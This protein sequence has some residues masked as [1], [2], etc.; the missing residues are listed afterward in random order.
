[1]VKKDEVCLWF[2]NSEPHRRLELLCGLLNMCLPME[3]RF[4]S[5]CVEDL[6]KRDFHDLRDAEHKA[7]STQEI[8]RLSN[9]L[10]ERTRS[11]LIVFVALLSSRN[12]TCSTLLYQI[13]AQAHQDTQ[14]PQPSPTTTTIDA[15]Y[16][17]E[18]A[19]AP[20][21]NT[22]QPQ[23]TAIDANYVKEVAQA[24]HNSQPQ[25]SPATIDANYV[26]EMAQAHHHNSQPQPTA[27]DA[28]CVKEMAQAQPL[29]TQ[30]QPQA[31]PTTTTIDANYVKEMLLIYTMVLHHPAF[32]FEQKR[33]IADLHA[34]A[35]KLEATRLSP[36]HNTTT[37]ELLSPVSQSC[38]SLQEGCDSGLS[39][40][41]EPEGDGLMEGCGGLPAPPSHLHHYHHHAPG[42]GGLGAAQSPE[43]GG[44]Q[45]ACSSGSGESGD[46]YNEG[47]TVSTTYIYNSIYEQESLVALT[48]ASSY[49]CNHPNN[50]HYYNPYPPM[51]GT[52]SRCVP[53]GKGSHSDGSSSEE[54]SASLI[55]NKGPPVSNSPL[56]SPQ[57]S[58]YVSPLQ[59]LSP[60][61]A[62]SPLSHSATTT[63][64]TTTTTL[65]S[66]PSTVVAS[67]VCAA[68]G[69]CSH[70]GPVQ[71]Q[72]HNTAAV[73][74][75]VTQTGSHTV[76]CTSGQPH[77][78]P[79]SS[80]SRSQR[81]TDRSGS[82]TRL[83]TAAIENDLATG[84]QS[85]QNS[86]SSGRVMNQPSHSINNNSN[87]LKNRWAGNS[88]VV[89]T[90]STSL[91]NSTPP[92]AGI[93]SNTKQ[94]P[95]PTSGNT[96]TC[97]ILTTATVTASSPGCKTTSV[98]SHAASGRFSTSIS[99]SATNTTRNTSPPIVHTGNQ[100]KSTLNTSTNSGIRPPLST[101]NSCSILPSNM[102]K[103]ALNNNN[104]L[105]RELKVKL[106]KHYQQ[107]AQYSLDMLKKMSD[108]ELMEM[109]LNKDEVRLLWNLL[110]NLE[111]HTHHL[112]NGYT[113]SSITLHSRSLPHSQNTITVTTSHTP[114]T[115]HSRSSTHSP[116]TTT[117]TC[118]SPCHS[119]R[120][121]SR[122]SSQSPTTTTITTTTTT[123]SRTTS[124]PVSTSGHTSP[125]PHSATLT[126]NIQHTSNNSKSGSSDVNSG[127]QKTI[128]NTQSIHNNAPNTSSNS[129]NTPGN[130]NIQ[131][132]KSNMSISTGSS[133]S[134]QTT[135]STSVTTTAT[136]SNNICTSTTIVTNSTA[137]IVTTVGDTVITSPTSNSPITT[138]V[139]STHC[140]A[141]TSSS[142]PKNASVSMQQPKSVQCGNTTVQTA[143]STCTSSTTSFSSCSAPTPHVS[144]FSVPP[145]PIPN[146]LPPQSTATTSFSQHQL[147]T[148]P[149]PGQHR[150]PPPLCV[151]PRTPSQE[152]CTHSTTASM[153]GYYTN[154]GGVG[155]KNNP[156]GANSS[157]S[158]AASSQ[159]SIASYS[160][161]ISVPQPSSAGNV[162]L[163]IYTSAGSM[164]V[165]TSSGNIGVPPPTSAGLIPMVGPGSQYHPTYIYPS[166]LGPGGAHTYVPPGTYAAAAHHAQRS[167]YMSQPLAPVSHVNKLKATPHPGTTGH[168]GSRGGSSSS[169]SS[170]SSG[171]TR[172]FSKGNHKGHNHVKSCTRSSDS[173]PSSSQYS[174]P[175]QTPSPDHTPDL[176]T[177]KRGKPG[178]VI[179]ISE[180]GE[181]IGLAGLGPSEDG[182]PPPYHQPPN[183]MLLPQTAVPRPRMMPYSQMGYVG[184]HQGSAGM[185]RYPGI[186]LTN[187]APLI[188][189]RN[190]LPISSDKSSR[191]TTPP[192]PGTVPLVQQDLQCCVRSVTDG[193]TVPIT[194]AGNSHGRNGGSPHG[195]ATLSDGSPLPAAHTPVLSG[196]SH[197]AAQVP[198]G[199]TSTGAP[200]NSVQYNAPGYPMI[201]NAP[202]LFPQ[203]PG[204]VPAH[205]SHVSNGFVSSP[206]AHN[207]PFSPVGNAEY[208]YPGQYHTLLGGSSQGGGGNGCGTPGGLGAPSTPGPGLSYTHYSPVLSHTPTPTPSAGAKKTCYNCGHVGHNGAECKE[209]NIEE[210]CNIKTARS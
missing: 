15:N 156:S 33:V 48:M 178:D 87:H 161:P 106:N 175:P 80:G 29:N 187:Q 14:P 182:T 52:V 194:L 145:P 26:K 160:T 196:A 2:K 183:P 197:P 57:S 51:L 82:R 132:S 192:V 62:S 206:L 116:T 66:L 168:S 86:P 92:A 173:S 89:V 1:M 65:A 189:P 135:T 210:M 111:S 172:G 126:G 5:T 76:T 157:V 164:P 117:T 39:V 133:P 105:S 34:Q 204:F 3:L 97:R 101:G 121:M 127:P 99:S 198:P 17:K 151:P 167:F 8:K 32:T 30:P 165:Y 169:S 95:C 128:S 159:L 162:A 77:R 42:V 152:P 129:K 16:V 201:M 91:S 131:S 13:L 55:P 4:I 122:V 102:H 170:C 108:R 138:Q 24:H 78:K 9:L 191:E 71:K 50:F 64:A 68:T 195:P 27:I 60:S 119:P 181:T 147:P 144:Q 200:H 209:A 38:N 130:P 176:N 35:S 47:G 103:S 154:N 10:E 205:S 142:S 120:T 7:N 109:G 58:P 140:Q 11:N 186:P 70:S 43:S 20:H 31:S 22:P 25:A 134:A 18:M 184:F 125:S 81:H 110:A 190:S 143:S 208:M 44:N 112:H 67:T 180:T 37:S 23:P 123:T 56:S 199:N 146:K 72:S 155:V 149:P 46:L 75:S 88:S 21:H 49:P 6:G 115:I 158:A 153:T 59:S 193:G 139:T 141:A 63:T 137:S 54:G 94:S 114:S 174:S 85:S 79:P 19:Q 107:L 148:Q 93:K 36:P 74:G 179:E 28:N 171:S 12:H 73:H 100:D 163:P 41:T 207:F 45:D 166:F 136:V 202:P 83:P 113:N 90:A 188:T 53:P 104:Y 185:L 203:F 177:E 84:N 150:T 40:G 118:H 61:R 96:T 124:S 98:S 69:S